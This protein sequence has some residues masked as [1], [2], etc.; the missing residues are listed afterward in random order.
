MRH[1]HLVPD[2]KQQQIQQQ[3][4]LASIQQ[5]TTMVKDIHRSVIPSTSVLKQEDF[6]IIGDHSALMAKSHSSI[7]NCI[8]IAGMNNGQYQIKQNH[9]RIIVKEPVK[10][11]SPLIFTGTGMH[12]PV[13]TS[14]NNSNIQSKKG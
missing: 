11:M 4:F 9:P 14:V 13:V 8:T 7:N 1:S 12:Q 2:V 10:T 3:S 5:Q 6:N